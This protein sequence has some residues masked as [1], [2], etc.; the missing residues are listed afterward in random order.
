MEQMDILT[1]KTSEKTEAQD[2]SWCCFKKQPSHDCCDITSEKAENLG[3]EAVIKP[4]A[5]SPNRHPGKKWWRC[6]KK[7]RIT[8][9]GTD[10]GINDLGEA[11]L[12]PPASSQELQPQ[13]IHDGAKQ[14]AGPSSVSAAQVFAR[15]TAEDGK[16]VVIYYPAPHNCVLCTIRRKMSIWN[17]SEKEAQII[18]CCCFKK[19]PSN[20][21]LD[22]ASQATKGLGEAAVNPPTGSQ[23]GQTRK[24]W[25]CLK[26]IWMTP[27]GTDQAAGPGSASGSQV[28]ARRTAEDGQE[29]VIYHPAP[30]NCVFCKI[31]RKVEAWRG[32]RGQ[33]GQ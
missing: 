22:V 28:F 17:S 8:P 30:H 12:N 23:A 1:E 20:A 21:S 18:S 29:E 31:G 10:Q 27:V 16:E 13:I 14:A 33:T 7:N 5:D 6:F 9:V 32:H 15:Y 2:F 3:E 25:S 24:W 26:N 4:P 19:Q 11:T